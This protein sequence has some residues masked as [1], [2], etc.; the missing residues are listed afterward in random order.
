MSTQRGVHPMKLSNIVK[1]VF[2]SLLMFFAAQTSFAQNLPKVS[3]NKLD[4]YYTANVT[5][6]EAKKLLEFLIE[7]EFTDGSRE[8][9]TQ[10]D[11]SGNTYEFKFNVKKGIDS[12]PDFIKIAKTLSTEISNDVFNKAPVDIHLMDDNFKLLRVVVAF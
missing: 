7:E 8:L 9:A 4:I 5:R 12:D 6:A 3:Q 10:L 1:A 11:K 2:C